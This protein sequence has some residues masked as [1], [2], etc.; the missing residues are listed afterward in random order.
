MRRVV[1]GTTCL[2]LLASA[3]S[4]GPREQWGDAMRDAYKNASR[5]RTA[6]A[7]MAVDVKVIETNIRQTPLPLIARLE[8]VVDFRRYEASLVG[9]R[10]GKTSVVFD[11]LVV[12]LPRS[13]SSIAASRHKQRLVRYEFE[14]EPETDLDDTDRRLA[15]GAG[16]ISPALAVELLNGV[17]TGSIRRDGTETVGGTRATHYRAKFSQDAAAREIDDE[18][19]REGVMRLFDTLGAQEDVFPGEV[20]IDDE[21]LARR[22]VF[23]LRQQKDRVNAFEMRAG[24]EFYDYG[25]PAT[26]R[27]PLRSDSVRSSR[28]RAFVVEFVRA[29]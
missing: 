22:I 5:Q 6:K 25:A 24:F 26:F 19:R 29:V 9:T 8:G 28:F 20:W 7:R 1:L 18:D 14:R 4:L 2:F 11:D 3:C 27:V 12:Y 10:T 21:G 16:M 13:P 17:L 15:V 23:V